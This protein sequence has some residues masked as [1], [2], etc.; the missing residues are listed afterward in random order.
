MLYFNFRDAQYVT[1][2]ADT[3]TDNYMTCV[4]DTDKINN[5]R[6]QNL[7]TFS[8]TPNCEVVSRDGL[9]DIS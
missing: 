4:V 6:N 1:F 3:I 7:Y 5:N 8:C 2:S 9:F